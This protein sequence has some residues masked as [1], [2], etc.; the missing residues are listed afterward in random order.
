MGNHGESRASLKNGETKTEA[1][2][3]YKNKSR[4]WTARPW[5]KPSGIAFARMLKLF[6]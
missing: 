6:Q 3:F 4:E 5:W 1:P 2:H